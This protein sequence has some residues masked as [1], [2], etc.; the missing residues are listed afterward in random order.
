MF[1]W[2]GPIQ[3]T[4]NRQNSPK[5]SKNLRTSELQADL[6]GSL[7]LLQTVKS[8][9]AGP[10]YGTNVIFKILRM[11]IPIRNR[12][13]KNLNLVYSCVHSSTNV[14]AKCGRL[15]SDLADIFFKNVANLIYHGT[16]WAGTK[17]SI[18]LSMNLSMNLSYEYLYNTN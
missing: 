15:L 4:E 1:V 16:S 13:F 8:S 5:I 2:R 14:A 7:I 17:F 3:I 6:Q 9:C 18:Y 11:Q 12:F 10:M